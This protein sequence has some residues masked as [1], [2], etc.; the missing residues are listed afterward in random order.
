MINQESIDEDVNVKSIVFGP[1]EN[2]AIVGNFMIMVTNGELER[3]V[4]IN[5]KFPIRSAFW[6]S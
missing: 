3:T 5:E 6:E 4:V 1:D 2:I